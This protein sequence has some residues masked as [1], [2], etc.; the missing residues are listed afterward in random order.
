[1]LLVVT[2]SQQSYPSNKE[3]KN[4]NEQQELAFEQNDKPSQ[5]EQDNDFEIKQQYSSISR[6]RSRSRTSRSRS[7]SRTSNSSSKTTS[8]HSH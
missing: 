2:E 5:Y 8:W 3:I 4:P 1:L 6:S 7:R